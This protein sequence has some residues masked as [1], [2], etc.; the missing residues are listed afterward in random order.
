MSICGPWAMTCSMWG[1]HSGRYKNRGPLSPQLPGRSYGISAGRTRRQHGLCSG[2]WLP[3]TEAHFHMR[4]ANPPSE[5]EGSS[6]GTAGQGYWGP[7]ALTHS[8]GSGPCPE[9]PAKKTRLL[10]HPEHNPCRESAWE[11]AATTLTASFGAVTQR[12][13]PVVEVT[14]RLKAKYQHLQVFS[15]WLLV[16]PG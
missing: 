2:P 4:A 16:S 11:K 14:E 13:C 6:P 15:L 5:G 12:F 10:P 8:E 9:R 1:T 7:I 3:V